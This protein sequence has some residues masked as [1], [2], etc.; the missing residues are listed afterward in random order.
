MDLTWIDDLKDYGDKDKIIE[1]L[2][3]GIEAYSDELVALLKKIKS[4]NSDKDKDFI[5]SVLE[6]DIKSIHSNIES[7]IE[8]IK[9]YEVIDIKDTIY[10]IES[11]LL[12]IG[13]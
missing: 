12:P 1:Y 11:E 7:V 3:G 2:D 6:K 4:T 9:K 10:N 8:Y 5:I 13:K